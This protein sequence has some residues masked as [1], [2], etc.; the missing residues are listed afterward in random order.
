[1][2]AFQEKTY[3]NKGNKGDSSKEKEEYKEGVVASNKPKGDVWASIQGDVRSDPEVLEGLFYR[4]E[5]EPCSLV[6]WVKLW[7]GSVKQ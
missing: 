2:D 4:G 1:M 3:T 7:T 6:I 5:G